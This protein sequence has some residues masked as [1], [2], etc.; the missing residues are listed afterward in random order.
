MNGVIKGQ[1]L[2]QFYELKKAIKNFAIFK[3]QS[4]YCHNNVIVFLKMST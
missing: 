4:S 2:M 3:T 1:H